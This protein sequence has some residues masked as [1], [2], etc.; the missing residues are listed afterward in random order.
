MKAEQSNL[1]E[2]TG[3][4]LFSNSKTYYKAL[5]NSN[6]NKNQISK[7]NLLAHRKNASKCTKAQLESVAVSSEWVLK[8]QGVYGSNESRSKLVTK[9]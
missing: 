2:D 7:P 4:F 8:Q 6:E 9:L 5:E 3:I 1:N